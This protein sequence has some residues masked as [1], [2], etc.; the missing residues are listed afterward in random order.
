[1]WLEGQKQIFSGASDFDFSIYG[2]ANTGFG[3]HE[4]RIIGTWFHVLIAIKNK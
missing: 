1:M 4:T 2:V 3:S